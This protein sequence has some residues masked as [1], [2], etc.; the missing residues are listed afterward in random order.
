MQAK[1]Q[2]VGAS[3]FLFPKQTFRLALQIYKNG[4]LPTQ[5]SSTLQHLAAQINLKAFCSAPRGPFDATPGTH[6]RSTSM[7]RFYSQTSCFLT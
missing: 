3:C 1:I 6:S 5:F 7:P 2:V 4:M